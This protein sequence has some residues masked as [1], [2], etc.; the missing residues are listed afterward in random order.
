[1]PRYVNILGVRADGVSSGEEADVLRSFFAAAHDHSDDSLGRVLRELLADMPN[2]RLYVLTV[3]EDEPWTGHVLEVTSTGE[4][5]EDID[6]FRE[7]APQVEAFHAR[8]GIPH[9]LPYEGDWEHRL[10]S[11]TE[12]R[13][14]AA[15]RA[16]SSTARAASLPI[17]PTSKAKRAERDALV[18][19]LGRAL[20][21]DRLD[22]PLRA[23]LWGVASW[24]DVPLMHERFL[25]AMKAN[26]PSLSDDLVERQRELVMKVLPRVTSAA[27]AEGDSRPWVARAVAILERWGL[28][29]NGEHGRALE[30]ARHLDKAIEALESCEDARLRS[31]AATLRL[32]RRTLTR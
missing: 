22:D 1:M 15:I 7:D 2:V 12:K 17:G 27:L 10:T 11:G 18:G 30:A 6:P 3:S 25:D 24:I 9:D 32:Q 26:D 4:Q 29:P 23:E 16:A 13:R 31:L 21:T 19:P 20:G 28:A 5:S 8:A 14:R